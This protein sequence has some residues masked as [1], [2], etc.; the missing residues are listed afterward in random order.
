MSTNLSLAVQRGMRAAQSRALPDG[1][2][3][4]A[5]MVEWVCAIQCNILSGGKLKVQEHDKV[6]VKELRKQFFKVSASHA[7]YCISAHSFMLSL[8]DMLFWRYGAG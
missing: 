8:G 2:P 7:N 6:R 5:Y 4:P 3:S 1:A